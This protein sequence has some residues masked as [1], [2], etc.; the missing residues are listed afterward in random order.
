LLTVAHVSD[1]ERQQ[2]SID[3]GVARL[4]ATQYG[5]FSRDQVASLGVTRGMIDRRLRNGRWESTE[6]NIFRAAGFLPSWRQSLMVACLTLGAGTY[7]SH[8]SASTLWP[9]AGIEA[10]GMELTIPRSR[11]RRGPWIVY[12]NTVSAGEIAKIGPFPV[13]TAARTLLDVASVVNLDLVEIA[14]DDA[15]RRGLVSLPRMRWHLDT[16]ERSRR[17]GVAALRKL[18][19]ARD[20]ASSVP[21]SVLETMLLRLILDAG[22]PPPRC[23]YEIL[24][25]GRILAVLDFAYPDARLGIEADGYEWHSGRARFEHD[26]T[27]SNRLTLLDWRILHVTWRDL[28]LRPQAVVD[29]IRSAL[30]SPGR[31]DQPTHRC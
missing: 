28:K 27:R 26:R 7:V 30:R 18:V 19:K 2:R 20:A 29:T 10:E 23:Q 12:Q 16:W 22:L 15:L 24:G 8:R 9:L 31:T 25:A 6:R 17:P 3:A 14:L 11:R 5:V 1:V 13:T 4:A 21:A